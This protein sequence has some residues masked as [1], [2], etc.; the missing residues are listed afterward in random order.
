MNTAI[1][2]PII[3]KTLPKMIARDLVGVQPMS[4]PHNKRYWPYQT[5]VNWN[6]IKEIERWCY[7]CMKSAHWRNYGQ[8]FAF[9][10]EQ[11]YTA[12]LLKWS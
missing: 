5:T 3:R 10:R 7:S 6:Q 8:F 11:D 12:F 9:K 4:S 1:M 2:I